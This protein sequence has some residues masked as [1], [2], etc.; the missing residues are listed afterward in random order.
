MAQLSISENSDKAKEIILANK[1]SVPEFVQ[2][3]LDCSVLPVVIKACQN[4]DSSI[5]GEISIYMNLVHSNR[6]K[7][8]GRCLTR[9]D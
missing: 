5:T 8:L 7:M 6:M 2:L 1:Q 3:L 4:S 9:E